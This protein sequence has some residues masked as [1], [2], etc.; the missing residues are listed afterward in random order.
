M[1]TDNFGPGVSPDSI[2]YIAA[3]RSLYSGHG[4]LYYDGTVFTV[5]PPLFPTIL[6][7]GISTG[8]DVL[9]FARFFNALTFGLTV[10]YVGLIASVLLNSRPLR[11][12]AT[13]SALLSFPLLKMYVMV[14]TEPLFILLI[15]IFLLRLSQVWRSEHLSI[16]SLAVLSA[17]AAVACLQRY[18]GLALVLC[19]AVFLLTSERTAWKN[20]LA[21]TAAFCTLSLLPLSLWVVR[22]YSLAGAPTGPRSSSST[23]IL[24]SARDLVVVSTNWFLPF[25]SALETR[26]AAFLLLTALIG[27]C[28]FIGAKRPQNEE[29]PSGRAF[30]I[31]AGLFIIIYCAMLVAVTG[32][33]AL[34]PISQRY[35][36]PIFPIALLFLFKAIE[37]CAAWL[38][39]RGVPRKR[40]EALASILSLAILVQSTF[41]TSQAISIWRREGAGDYTHIAWERSELLDWLSRNRLDGEI[42]S[43]AAD[44]IYLKTGIIARPLPY[45]GSDLAAWRRTLSADKKHYGA[46]FGQSFRTYLA[47]PLEFT[48]AFDLKPVFSRRTELLAELK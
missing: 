37:K 24:A 33:I 23:S 12:I 47:S 34:E 38:A 15:L 42:Y 45:R 46:W 27:A 9:Q 17:V 16:G 19:G 10:F 2:N 7:A 30:V 13:A 3:A 32:T 39:E 4:Y 21:F 20:R 36:S 1:A 40:A 18:L 8:V 6:A 43:N 41:T 48:A 22:N 14:W 11:A 28:L 44:L 29:V 25:D 31:T 5:W 26:V 35:L